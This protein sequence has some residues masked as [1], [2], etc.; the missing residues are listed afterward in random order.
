MAGFKT[1]FLTFVSAAMLFSAPVSGA[2]A[3]E[4]ELVPLAKDQLRATTPIIGKKDSLDILGAVDAGISLDIRKDAQE[5]A[6]LSYGA[7]GGLAFRSFY[8]A[9][10]LKGQEDVLDKVFDF[11]QLLVKAPSGLLIEPPIVSEADNALIVAKGGIEAAVADRIYN[12]NKNAKIVT[13]P[14]NWRQYIDPVRIEEIAKPPK[15]LWPQTKE[16]EK[17]W[18]THFD[19][20]WNAGIDQANQIFQSNIERLTSDFNGMI[21]YR[22]MVAQG[23]ISEPYALHEDRGITG[24]KNEMRIGDRALRITGPSEFKTG[25][26]TWHPADR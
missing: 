17:R 18:S 10:E 13:A 7:R 15:I 12:I 16:E 4:T 9:E 25:Y 6:A 20:G 1:K 2:Y 19:K 21:L 22:I 5:E 26:D 11:Q 23:M 24:G 14:R 8:I 3:Q